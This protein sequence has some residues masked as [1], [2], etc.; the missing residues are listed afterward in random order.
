MAQ[1]A[2]LSSATSPEMFVIEM[3]TVARYGGEEFVIVLPESDAESA[4]RVAE[5]LR[6][7][8]ESAPFAVC[9]RSDQRITISIGISTLNQNTRFKRDLIAQA[10]TALYGAKHRGRNLVVV[11][12]EAA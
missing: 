7:S 4:L 6:E 8:V 9:S 10:D 11:Y 1:T 3:D 5:R 12:S 2:H